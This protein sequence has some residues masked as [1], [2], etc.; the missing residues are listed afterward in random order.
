MMSRCVCEYVV[1]RPGMEWNRYDTKELGVVSSISIGVNGVL[2]VG[3]YSNVLLLLDSR[4]MNEDGL[5]WKSKIGDRGIHEVSLK[6]DGLLLVNER[7]NGKIHCY[8]TRS[9]EKELF[10]V[11]YASGSQQVRD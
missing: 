4:C 8:D 3:S 7:Y 5:I 10:V 9:M 6:R 11:E 1:D 2:G